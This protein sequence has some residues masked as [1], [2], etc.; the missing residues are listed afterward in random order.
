MIGAALAFLS[1]VLLLHQL[2]ELPSVW[3]L[4]SAPLVVLT[5]GLRSVAWL[6]GWC[7]LGFL[8]TLYW[9]LPGPQL[10]PELQR[11]DLIAEGW[12]AD[13]PTTGPRH[14]RFEFTLYQLRDGDTEIPLQG[15]LRLSW[16]RT[17]L[18]E[19]RVGDRWRFTV[20]LLRPRGSLNPGAF[21]YERWLY[22]NRIGATGYVVDRI[23]SEL[24]ATAERHSINRLRQHI[25]ERMRDW[26]ADDRY[27]GLLTA[28]A[29][30][31]R[32][33]IERYQWQVLQ[34]TGTSHLLAISG[35]HVG[36]VAG[37]VFLLA[38]WLW[39]LTPRLPLYWPAPKAGAVIALLAALGYA[40]LA[41]LSLPTQRALVMLGVAL[42]AL[43][44]ER[45][46]VP[47]QLLALAMLAVLIYD[48]G[49]PLS[50]GFW[51]SFGAVA[52]LIYVAAGHYPQPGWLWRWPRL[53]IAIV[54][55]LAPATLALFQH[56]SLVS[57]LANLIAIPWASVLLV[58]LTLLG[59]LLGALSDTLAGWVLN[60]ANISVDLLWRWLLG[61]LSRQ[62]WARLLRPAPPLIA[63]AFAVP[64]LILL[65]GPRGLPGR[66]LGIPLCLP[67]FFFP[68]D[69]PPPGTV[70]YTQLDIGAGLASVVRTT[71]HT[72]VYDT[73][74]RLSAR[75]DGGGMALV[76]FLRREGVEVVDVLM[77]S[78][79]SNQHT[80]GTRSLLRALPAQRI[81]TSDPGQ[82][83][84]RGAQACHSG[85]RWSWDE[86]DF[87]ILHPPE[88]DSLSDGDAS[89]V[90]L[91]ETGERRLLLAGNLEAAGIR[92]LLPALSNS[93]DVLVAPHQGRRPLPDPTL[94][95]RLQPR[96]V[97]FA[98]GY[99]NRW[100]YPRP[101]TV[102]A[103]SATGAELMDT[104]DSGAIRI[105]LTPD[106]PPLIERYREQARRYWHAR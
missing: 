61:P 58:P 78:N 42:L 49:A 62:D 106:R 64:G 37:M 29:I 36:L 8:W 96:Y 20:R 101:E 55:G 77:L 15:R 32:Q 86:V 27:R 35:L 79:P 83:P 19:L 74:P 57:P 38:H 71:H 1:G 2:P 14:T 5:M 63:L 84:I 50:G 100:G 69:T 59:V 67:L 105:E 16:Y 3:W 102:T 72:L 17:P 10:P 9:A 22:V 41:G 66:W 7:A 23:E 39:S 98:T 87:T 51:L 76:P 46:M 70:R 21:D 33:D 48:P 56:L 26:I 60:L 89:C 75:L 97:L 25:R 31:D 45:P 81:L 43:L 4:M 92:A 11:A 34:T 88:R 12:I 53:Q 80:G 65:L 24:L 82:V 85:M 95:A 91:I 104:V 13:L 94:L 47:S 28:L 6:P 90:L 93:V 52:T 68:T 18:P 30:G 40:L 73:G 99:R 54:L 103:Y 44:R